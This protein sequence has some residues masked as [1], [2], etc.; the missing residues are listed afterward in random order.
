MQVVVFRLGGD[1]Y[2]L[3]VARVREIVA[4]RPPRSLPA[5]EPWHVGVVSLRDEIVAVWDLSRRLGVEP[6]LPDAGRVLVVVDAA[7]PVA[8]VVDAVVGIR[9]LARDS[10]E[11]LPRWPE[12]AGIADLEGTL[13][14]VLD[15][16][17]LLGSGAGERPPDGLETLSTRELQRRA[18][19]AGIAGRSKMDREQ[20]LAALRGG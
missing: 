2:A 11:P 18:R 9:E 8:L 17:R 19:A 10:L 6:R 16:D 20:L 14:V 15:A 12:A 7:E 5:S 3:D 1:A 13:V 4:Y